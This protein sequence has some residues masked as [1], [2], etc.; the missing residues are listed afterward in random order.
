MMRILTLR[1]ALISVLILGS[2]AT[3]FADAPADQSWSAQQREVWETVV[4]WN[5]AF[6]RNDPR[7]YFEFIDPAITVI[8]PGSPYRISGIEADRREFE[9]SLSKGHTRVGYFQEIDPKVNVFGSTRF[10]ERRVASRSRI[11]CSTS[12]RDSGA[13]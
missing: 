13:A 8:T 5:R 1:L 12:L 9:F 3:G 7:A 11:L 2:A 6:E 4:A 10:H